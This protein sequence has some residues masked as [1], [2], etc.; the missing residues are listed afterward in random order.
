MNNVEILNTDLVLVRLSLRGRNTNDTLNLDESVR[1]DTL[2]LE[3]GGGGA[4]AAP[5]FDNDKFVALLQEDP[6]SA[7]RMQSDFAE[8]TADFLASGQVPPGEA[9]AEAIVS[10]VVETRPQGHLY[11]RKDAPEGYILRTED[12]NIAGPMEL[13]EERVWRVTAVGTWGRC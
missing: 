13:G 5:E 4:N 8:A 10:W 1:V 7:L 2:N 3:L 6:E 9:L 12:I 11:V